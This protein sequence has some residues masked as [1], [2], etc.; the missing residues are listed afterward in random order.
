M[1]FNASPFSSPSLRVCVPARS[2]ARAAFLPL[3]FMW[4]F[5]LWYCSRTAKVL[6]P[7]RKRQH[8]QEP[9]QRRA[10]P[11][12]QPQ[13]R[14]RQRLSSPLCLW[15]R[16]S[17]VR[18]WC[19]RRWWAWWWWRRGGRPRQESPSEIARRPALATPRAAGVPL[20]AS[21]NTQY[22]SV[23]SSKV[24]MTAWVE[25]VVCVRGRR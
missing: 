22:V 18:R 19:P 15:R 17:W 16:G 4:L 5:S 23:D 14:S 20:D 25:Q 10:S 21:I 3:F 2:T 11:P 13:P 9:W 1:K 12:P 7:P 24:L 8:L 6:R